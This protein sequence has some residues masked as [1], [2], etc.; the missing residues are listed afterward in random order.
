MLR[1]L[2]IPFAAFARFRRW[3]SRDR[4]TLGTTCSPP[5]M[6][7]EGDDARVVVLDGA[8]DRPSRGIPV[9]TVREFC[10]AI[11]EEMESESAA[12]QSPENSP[13]QLRSTNSANDEPRGSS[14]PSSWDHRT[15][16][17]EPPRART[18]ANARSRR[19]CAT[20]S[21]PVQPSPTRRL[22][23]SRRRTPLGSRKPK[24]NRSRP[25]SPRGS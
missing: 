2:R 20:C 8:R 17:S 18:E 11:I 7:F 21:T 19:S 6:A 4:G 24:R 25:R 23:V 16:S 15:S 22:A 12:P 14:D 3:S 5:S 10:Q 13:R 1:K 9:S